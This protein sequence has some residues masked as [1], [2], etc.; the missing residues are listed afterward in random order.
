M[1]VQLLLLLYGE[2]PPV[3]PPTQ[4]TK[5]TDQKTPPP[6]DEK[7]I[8]E[9]EWRRMLDDERKR[10]REEARVE[11]EKQYIDKVISEK[12][13][14]ELGL[15]SYADLQ[16]TIKEV[17]QD[18]EEDTKGK[19][20]GKEGES[21]EEMRALEA[22]YQAE[23]EKGQEEIERLSKENTV[24]QTEIERDRVDTALLYALEKHHVLSPKMLVTELRKSVKLDNERQPIVINENGEPRVKIDE[25]IQ[26]GVKRFRSIDMTL[27][28]LVDDFLKQ[29]ENQHFLPASPREGSGGRGGQPLDRTMGRDADYHAKMEEAV[30]KG[31]GPTEDFLKAWQEKYKKVA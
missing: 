21:S 20:K 12:T 31:Q 1:F 30:R 27:D 11:V 15:K 22:R 5:T 24:F 7:M 10:V 17:L 18:V 6:P 4:Q 19:G 23:L 14:A 16:E 8:P 26:D 2:T 3:S 29:K 25:Y 13:L 9:S 28:D